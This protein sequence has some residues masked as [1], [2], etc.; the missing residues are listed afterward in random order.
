MFVEALDSYLLGSQYFGSYI[1]NFQNPIIP[2][3]KKPRQFDWSLLPI[4][5]AALR[6]PW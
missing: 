4:G 6:V 1:K 3:I 2:L 5:V